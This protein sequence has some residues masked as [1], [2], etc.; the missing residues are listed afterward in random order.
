MARIRSIKPSFWS[1]EDLA[2]L[3]AWHRLCFI[4]LWNYADREGR[5]EDRPRRLKAGIFPFDDLEMGQLLNGLQEKGFILRYAA[6]GAAYIQVLNFLKHQRPKKDEHASLIPAPL[7][8]HS[9]GICAAPR[10]G[11]LEDRTLGHEDIGNSADVAVPAV[12]QRAEDLQEA[13]NSTTKPPIPRCRDLTT[14]R[15]RQCRSRLT[16]RPLSEWV[17]VFAEIQASAFC[18]GANDRGWVASFDWAIGSPDVAVKVLEGKYADRTAKRV[19]RPAKRHW[20]D[21][22]QEIHG[23]TCDKQW[24]HEMRKRESV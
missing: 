12:G 9:R 8:E 23:G 3:S 21:E 4:G 18:G 15:R 10:L 11:G 5:L 2:E 16:E 24:N 22:C 14:K 17:T 13:W 7:L 19:E 1:N 20:F 6:D